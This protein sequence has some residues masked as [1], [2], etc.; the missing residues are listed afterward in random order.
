[1]ATT[2]APLGSIS[3][4]IDNAAAQVEAQMS[5]DAA[6][7][8]T[9]TEG[10]VDEQPS[11]DETQ[12][13]T[14]S[15]G[16]ED[17]AAEGDSPKPADGEPEQPALEDEFDVQPDKISPDQKTYFYRAAKAQR[18]MAAQDFQR[19]VDEVI[20]GASIEQLEQHYKRSVGAQQMLDDFNSGDPDAMQRWM[21]FHVN[22]NT[23]PQAI[24]Y[25]TESLLERLPQIN[26]SIYQ[27]V[28]SQV[29]NNQLERMYRK[30]METGNEELL[31]LAQHLDNHLN[32]KWRKAEELQ[33]RD[34]FQEE[35]A[36]FEQ[37]RQQ[38]HAER[39]AEARRNA[40]RIVQ[41]TDGRVETAIGEEIEA[42]LAPVAASFKDKPQ[43]RF[44]FRELQDK[45]AEARRANPTWAR[46]YE[47]LR[48]RVRQQPTD[49]ARQQLVDT[50][51]TFAKRVVSQ[52]RK[53]VIDS[54]TQGVLQASA[55]ANQK[56]QAAAARREPAGGGAPVNRSA[57][58]VAQAR[59]IRAK[60]GSSADILKAT[61]GW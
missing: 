60:G 44:M 7:T 46:Q 21:D 42:A 14:P 57:S 50:M 45:V 20:P 39:A 8:D 17:G 6:T 55:A 61:L 35:R 1:M 32:G 54:V 47:N 38:F 30:A 25:M 4:A 3:D 11:A 40:D 26:R 59:E 37:E 28:E 52:S 9:Q 31:H 10:A 18:L 53:A 48:Q 24:A 23:S 27:R 29:V 15:E 58:V 43:W 34:P 22:S 49:E 56:S 2:P 51:R 5:A 13:Q 41:E 16:S 12:T 19:R 33:R 36:R